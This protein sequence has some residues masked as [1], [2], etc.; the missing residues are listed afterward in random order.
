MSTRLEFRNNFRAENPEIT[1]NVISDSLLNAW[2]L[3]GNQEICAATFCILSNESY[4]F[5]SS[6][7][8]QYYD[9]EAN[10]NKVYAIDDMPG[11]GVYFDNIPVKK[12]TPGEMNYIR[13]S[14]KTASPGIPRRYWRRGKYLWFE[15]KPSAVKQ[16]AIDAYLLPDDFDD[17]SKMPF[18]NLG[19]LIPFHDAMIKYLQW[20]C[21]EKIGKD[22]EGIK[23]ELA[24][25]K[26][27]AMMKSR[28]KAGNQQSVFF[29]P[30]SS[31]SGLPRY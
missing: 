2:M 25:T 6:T 15:V 16:I 11:G 5:N 19:H 28:C 1:Q 13:K 31:N 10:I 9:L 18:N 29:R 12:V 20:K 3:K 30:S 17:D 14:W 21:K 27:V 7:T 4:T 22:D 26:Y 8:A 23:A 24:Y